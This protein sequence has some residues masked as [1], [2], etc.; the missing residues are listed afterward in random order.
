MP[1]T[2]YT[3][4]KLPKKPRI[5]F[6]GQHSKLYNCAPSQEHLGVVA[7]GELQRWIKF[8]DLKKEYTF[9]YINCMHTQPDER[10]HSKKPVRKD[11]FYL[12]NYYEKWGP[13]VA[14]YALG[15]EAS[16]ALK[17][18][19]ILHFKLPHPSPR[20]TKIANKK[21][22]KKTLREA[23]V[24]LERREEARTSDGQM[25]KD[26]NKT[27]RQAWGLFTSFKKRRKTT[28]N[29]HNNY[30]RN[31]AASCEPLKNSK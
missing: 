26:F 29:K 5:L 15:Y 31:N 18:L 30:S 14:V 3:K 25:W 11:Y 13:Y 19:E 6:V 10:R 20:N 2:W 12:L 28:L 9:K 16:E 8:W 4:K 22:L 21:F 7:Y 24:Y 27:L 17:K 23:K 1:S